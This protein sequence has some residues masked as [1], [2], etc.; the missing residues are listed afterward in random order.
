MGG[1]GGELRRGS[2]FLVKNPDV[3]YIRSLKNWH[4]FKLAALQVHVNNF[5]VSLNHFFVH[6]VVSYLTTE[7]LIFNPN[8]FFALLNNNYFVVWLL[9]Q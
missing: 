1:G 4:S 9:L 7:F 5:I 2:S 8:I 6:F 3:V